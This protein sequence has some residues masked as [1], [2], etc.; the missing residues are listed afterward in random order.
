MKRHQQLTIPTILLLSVL[1]SRLHAQTRTVTGTVTADG[2]PLSGVT[3]SEE[4]SEEAAVTGASGTYQISVQSERPVL[5]FRHPNFGERREEIGSQTVFDLSLDEKVSEI[6]EVVLNAGY[7]EVKAKESTGSISKVTAKDIENQPVTNVLSAIQGRMA[8]VNITQNSGVPG[9]GY[10]VQIR[11]R[12]SLRTQTNSNMDGNMPLYVVDGVVMGGET[13]SQYSV[14]IL[15][16][17]GINP[18]NAIHP[19]DIES[20]EILKDADATAIY[21]SR[22]ANGVVLVTTKRIGHSPLRLSLGTM[23]SVSQVA[24][25]MKMLGTGDYLAMRR[26]AYANDGISVFPATAYDI[27]GKWDQTRYTDWQKELTGHTATASDHQLSLSGGRQN[28]QFLV[29]FN[30]RDQTTVFGKDFRYKTNSAMSKFTH[31]SDDSRFTL[32]FTNL[33]SGSSNNLVSEDMT[34]RALSLVPD[35]PALYLPDGSLNWENNTF[36]NPVAIHNSTY[37]NDDIQMVNSLNL[38]YRVLKDMQVR[39]NTGLTY[40]TFEEWSLRPNT[41]FNPSFVTGQSSLY[42][43]VSTSTGRYLSLLL[44]PQV[45]WDRSFGNHAVE[46]LLGASYQGNTNQQGSM[47]GSGFE[48]NALLQNIAAAQTKTVNDQMTT[49]Y[50]YAAAFSRINYRYAGRYILNLTGR[51]DGSSRFGPSNRFAAFGAVGAAWIFSKEKWLEGLTFL[52]FGK[53]RASYGSA[54]SDN[55]GDYQYL[56]TYTVSNLIYNGITGMLP[57][58]LFNPDYSWE[59]TVKSEVALELGFLKD[60]L[61]LT[62]SWYRNRSSNQLVGYQLP[63]ITGFSS[64]QANLD[65]TVENSGIELEISA[66]PVQTGTL[67]W[68]TA[69]N[70]SLPRSR[71]VSFPGLEGSTYASSFVVGEPTN[72]IKLYQLEGL[73]PQTGIYRF[74]DFNGDGRISADDRQVIARLGAE[75]FGGWQNSLQR[76]NW[77]LSFLLQFVKQQALNYNASM[78]LPGGMFGQPVEVLDVWSPANPSGTYMPYST[79]ASSV[80]ST[81]HSNFR[82]STASVSDASFVRLKN[83]QISYSPRLSNTFIRNMSIYVQGQNLWKYT[84]YFGVDPEFA[85]TGY[86]PPLRSIAMGATFNF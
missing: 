62:A 21:G 67:K 5:L 39:L 71:L 35:A 4:G 84:K 32:A 60:R 77:N 74:T 85:V 56:D 57:S 72:I 9:G 48:S 75:Y 24:S 37:S 53:L 25:G 30:H 34:A 68:N 52:S 43:S 82:S 27:N 54:G 63:A 3:V 78:P 46:L 86:L 58:R 17:R 64:V 76:G 28:T 70:I 42:S 83:V 33:F 80:H 36:T 55:I 38:S 13:P 79:G 10:D 18:L 12:N 73:D 81:V 8:G 59:K 31:R 49:E 2:K 40:R 1:G 50:R 14:S 47:R 11:G 6:K 7:Y 20:I 44:E 26:Q 16:L 51:R 29:S 22:G 23:F 61:N 45:Q 15:P 19:D 65:A 66:A 41:I 69:F